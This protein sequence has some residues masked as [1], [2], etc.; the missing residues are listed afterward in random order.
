MRTYIIHHL[1]VFAG[2]Y[3][4]SISRCGPTG[5]VANLPRSG[6]PKK[7]S[8]EARAFIDQQMQTNGEMTS[9]QIQ[10]KLE[11][12]IDHVLYKAIPAVVEVQ[13]TATKF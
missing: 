12:Y 1:F 5:S 10:K 6:R 3:I 9:S 13:G 8:E 11:K 2:C 4:G 7:L